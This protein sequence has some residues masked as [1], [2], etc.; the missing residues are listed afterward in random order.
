MQ[1]VTPERKIR[2]KRLTNVQMM[3]SEGGGES[4]HKRETEGKEEKAER[5]GGEIKQ[6]YS[7]VSTASPP[8]V[9]V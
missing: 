5:E 3:S 2:L 8:L 1:P 6:T 9:S 7:P 4:E